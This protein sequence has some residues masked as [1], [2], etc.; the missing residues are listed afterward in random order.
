MRLTSDSKILI[1]VIAVT[2]VLIVGAAFLLTKPAPALSRNDLMPPT[3]HTKG[4]PQANAYLVEFSD[5]QCP[6]CAAIKPIVDELIKA[7]NEK[8]TFAYRHYPLLQHPLSQ[9]AALAAEA[10]GLQGK[11][12][13]MY[14]LI[15]AN[16]A[17]L[18]EPM[19]AEFAGQLELD[20]TLFTSDMKS[21]TLISRVQA[22]VDAGNKINLNATPTFFLNGKKLELND[23]A[24]FKNTVEQALQ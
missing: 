23:F 16:S 18:N 12:W 19:L 21:E 24:D 14:D 20:I 6:A 17:T 15:F 4:N 1:T 9:K 5:F 2:I 3:A 10:A 13:E 22:D 11:F 8:L 7:H